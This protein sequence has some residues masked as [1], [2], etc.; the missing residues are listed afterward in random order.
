MV[1][2]VVLVTRCKI[3]SFIV[4]LLIGH[5]IVAV[6]DLILIIVVNRFIRGFMVF[7]S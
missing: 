3:K 5:M 2:S 7:V 4:L 6:V 1:F